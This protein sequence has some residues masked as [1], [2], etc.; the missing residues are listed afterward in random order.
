[1]EHFGLYPM[2]QIHA[3]GHA[4]GTEIKRMIDEMRP[5]KVIPVHTQHPEE[6]GRIV[7]KNIKVEFAKL[8]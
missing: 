4:P 7:G 6:F 2:H 8:S 1:M 3:S 5:K